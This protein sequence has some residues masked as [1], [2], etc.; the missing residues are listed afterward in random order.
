MIDTT[1]ML[2]CCKECEFD[3]KLSQWKFDDVFKMS[4]C[5]VADV[6]MF[7]IMKEQEK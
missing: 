4:G 1:K 2:D 7:K 5:I 3:C 6:E